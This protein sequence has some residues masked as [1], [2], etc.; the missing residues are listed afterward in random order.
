MTHSAAP[1]VLFSDLSASQVH[2]TNR[3]LLT[4]TIKVL[5]LDCQD[6]D[7]RKRVHAT[8]DPGST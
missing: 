8:Q 4:N 7:I 1:R 3:A 6:V 2:A 5:T